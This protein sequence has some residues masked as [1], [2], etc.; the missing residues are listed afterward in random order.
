MASPIRTIGP[1]RSVTAALEFSGT[2][3]RG[4]L[5]NEVQTI[6]SVTVTNND[7]KNWT[8]KLEDEETKASFTDVFAPGTKSVLTPSLPMKWNPDKLGGIWD[9][10]NIHWASD[11]VR[12]I[13]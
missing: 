9:G 11:P 6:I 2:L 4:S 1:N 7:V 12:G 5:R 3:D 13:A 10:L 8:L